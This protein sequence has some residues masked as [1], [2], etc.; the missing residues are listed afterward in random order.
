MSQGQHDTAQICLNGHVV[1]D[2]FH[3][4][5]QFNQKFCSQCGELTITQCEQC[6]KPIKGH[7]HV[8]GFV[9]SSQPLIPENFCPDCG[10]P[11]PWFAKK[12]NVAKELAEELEEL[13]PEEREK[14][15]KS[16]DDLVRDT[17]STELAGIRFK[18]IMK[19]VGKGSYE[20]MKDVL[21][22]IVSE[23]AKKAIFGS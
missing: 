12:L 22:D 3:R 10:K 17:P 1:N 15:R 5:P 11:Y 19:K 18:K 23:T 8:P 13:T 2:S 16:L 6:R 14:L 20:M 4:Y 7:F 21:T 9:G